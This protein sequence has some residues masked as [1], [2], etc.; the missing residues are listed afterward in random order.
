MQ[1][2]GTFIYEC[3]RQP[4]VDCDNHE[5]SPPAVLDVPNPSIRVSSSKERGYT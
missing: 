3:E 2:L 1:T 4:P 5:L